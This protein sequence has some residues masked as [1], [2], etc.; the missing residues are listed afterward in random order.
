ME[1]PAVFS[2]A[3]EVDTASLDNAWPINTAF[4]LYP[5][6]LFRFSGDF[7]WYDSRSICLLSALL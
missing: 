7:A 5:G 4:L 3:A 1:R 6:P 2:F